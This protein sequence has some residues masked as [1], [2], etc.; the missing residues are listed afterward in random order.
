MFFYIFLKCEMS[1]LHFY[2]LKNIAEMKLINYEITVS[3]V[4]TA[5]Q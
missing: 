2:K 3:I 1:Y 5:I 4:G